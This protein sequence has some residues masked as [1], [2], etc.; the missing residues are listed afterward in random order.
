MCSSGIP[1]L[2]VLSLKTTLTLSHWH[3]AGSL[4]DARPADLQVA[5]R[6][7]RPAVV[8]PLGELRHQGRH[9][10]AQVVSRAGSP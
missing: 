4:G 2:S 6:R 3:Q 8:Q 7:E 9:L 10:L 5:P 1:V